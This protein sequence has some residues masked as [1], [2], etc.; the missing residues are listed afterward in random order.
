MDKQAIVEATVARDNWHCMQ[1]GPMSEW[2]R[3]R[4]PSIFVLEVNPS[5]CSVCKA[6]TKVK[7]C[8]A[9]LEVAY[10][11][12]KCQKRDWKTHRKTCKIYQTA[13][14][15]LQTF[16]PLLAHLSSIIHSKIK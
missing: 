15:N 10:C 2:E 3:V 8:Q 1:G 11:G 16:F 14:I 5:K 6:T 7:L 9:C 4:E 13:R 12:P